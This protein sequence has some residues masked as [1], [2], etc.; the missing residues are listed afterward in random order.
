MNES[1]F[2]EKSP[3]DGCDHRAPCKEEL[4]ACK[5]FRAWVATGMIDERLSREPERSHYDSLFP[6]RDPVETAPRRSGE[7]VVGDCAD[8]IQVHAP[9]IDQVYRE[10]I[11]SLECND[12]L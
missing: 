7:I 2:Y 12:G 4:L 6:N 8:G 11:E 10:F 9:G 3:C 5:L 1:I